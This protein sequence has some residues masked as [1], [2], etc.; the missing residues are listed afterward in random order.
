MH[1]HS[2][3]L[4]KPE[5]QRLIESVIARRRLGTQLE[6]R[7]VLDAAGCAVTQATLSRDLRE[8]GVEKVDDELGR[9]RYVLSGRPPGREPRA[10]LAEILARY[11]RGLT[12][13]QNIVVIRSELGS[14]PAIARALDRARHPLVVGTL[15]GDD[16]CLVIAASA[17]DAEALVRELS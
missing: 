6:L 15:A 7:A 9:P 16:T 4:T 13:A 11:G 5:R 14:A 1:R 17:G 10:A 12:A 3:R 2:R 8:L